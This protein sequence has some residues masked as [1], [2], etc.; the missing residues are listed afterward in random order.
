M[1]WEDF[2]Y[3]QSQFEGAFVVKLKMTKEER[4]KAMFD[5]YLRG[6]LSISEMNKMLEIMR[7][8]DINPK[9][10]LSGYA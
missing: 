10:E 3:K 2:R 6:E 1:D 5:R 9:S 4:A 8:K 7:P